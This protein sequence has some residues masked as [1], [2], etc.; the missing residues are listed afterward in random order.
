MEIEIVCNHSKFAVKDKI[1]REAKQYCDECGESF[2]NFVFQGIVSDKRK[3][4]ENSISCRIRYEDEQGYFLG[5]DEDTS[6]G[7]SDSDEITLSVPVTIPSNTVKAKILIE[8]KIFPTSNEFWDYIIGFA[9]I[10]LAGGVL[11][12]AAKGFFNWQ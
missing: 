7:N 12:Y 11:V 8:E 2:S 6:Y 4:K 3:K 1:F 5:L 9:V 10:I